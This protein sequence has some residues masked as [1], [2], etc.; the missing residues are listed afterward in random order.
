MKLDYRLLAF[1]LALAGMTQ[2][3]KATPVLVHEY[4]FNGNLLDSVGSTPIQN[5]NGGTVGAGVFSFGPNQGPTLAAESSLASSYSIGLEFK[6]NLNS[7]GTSV[8][9]SPNGWVSILNLSNLVYDSNNQYLFYGKP[10]FY[11][12]SSGSGVIP[13]NTPVQMLLTW[14]GTNYKSYLNGSLQDSFSTPGAASAV[15]VSG[16]A[17]FQFFQDDHHTS[18]EATSGSV[19]QIRVWDG[20]LTGGA[21]ASAFEPVPDGSTTAVLLGSALLGL[22]ALRRRFS[23]A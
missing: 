5:N 7:D 2:L 19:S 11:N 4:D 13:N 3:A 21:V 14:D 16:N 12:I 6:L 9:T 15:V 22:A 23:R 17:I 20:A 8:E 10:T 18:T 1:A